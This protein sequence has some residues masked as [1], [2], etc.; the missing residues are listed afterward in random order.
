MTIE[1]DNSLSAVL[2]LSESPVNSSIF[3]NFC[4]EL[5][6]VTVQSFQSVGK[7]RPSLAQERALAGFFQLSLEKLPGVW[8]SLTTKLKLSAPVNKHQQQSVN[9][10][11][12]ELLLIEKQAPSKEQDTDKCSRTNLSCDESIA[13]RYAAGYVT[14]KLL[15]RYSKQSTAKAALFV[16]CLSHMAMASTRTCPNE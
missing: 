5:I 7:V 15:K 11:L 2:R 4:K 8:S 12:F 13:I 3:E 16:E 14:M 9:R 1:G 10:R 6:S